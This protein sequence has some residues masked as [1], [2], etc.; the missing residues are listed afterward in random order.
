MFAQ[1]F[2]CPEHGEVDGHGEGTLAQ[3]GRRRSAGR[4]A[5]DGGSA[6]RRLQVSTNSLSFPA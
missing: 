6:A 3:A 4:R 2:I 5:R 1:I